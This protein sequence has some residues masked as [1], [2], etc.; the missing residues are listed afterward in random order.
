MFTVYQDIYVINKLYR[1]SDSHIVFNFIIRDY[2]F[3]KYACSVE[4]EGKELAV[5]HAPP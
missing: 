3:Q 1:Q 4:M 5:C 2:H